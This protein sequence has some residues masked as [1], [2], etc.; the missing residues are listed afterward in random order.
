MTF[1]EFLTTL[2]KYVAPSK[3]DADY[4]D[5]I[6]SNCL[7]SDDLSDKLCKYGRVQK[8]YLLNGERSASAVAAKA[9]EHY[10]EDIFGEFILETIVYE[11][12]NDLRKEFRGYGIKISKT[13]YDLSLAG[14]F[15]KILITEASKYRANTPHGNYKLRSMLLEENPTGICPCLGCGNRLS[16]QPEENRRYLLLQCL[17]LDDGPKD[18]SN[19]IGICDECYQSKNFDFEDLRKKKTGFL[20]R[21]RA[22]TE[23]ED[24]LFSERLR[25]AAKKLVELRFEMDSK[26]SYKS[27]TIYQKISSDQ[28]LLLNKIRNYIVTYFPLLREVFSE[29]DG[30]GY[31]FDSL[32]KS[33]HRMYLNAEIQGLDQSAIFSVLSTKISEVINEELIVGEIIVSFF[34]Q[35]CEVFH[36]ISK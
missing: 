32:S 6:F 5:L 18:Y 12:V 16:L 31:S 23:M 14:A 22:L 17:F 9:I 33:I 28:P 15:R 35:T 30:N 34:V 19:S 20:S 4:F 36:E 2:K 3:T 27:L 11:N 1:S 26:L 25:L 13:D 8:F 21:I 24:P 7:D 29:S 10:S